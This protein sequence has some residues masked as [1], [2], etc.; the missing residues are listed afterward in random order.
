MEDRLLIKLLQLR[1]RQALVQAVERGLAWGLWG[2]WL[3]LPLLLLFAGLRLEPEEQLRVVWFWPALA[4]IGF[5]HGL[6]TPWSLRRV[7][8]AADQTHDLQER[9]LTCYGHLESKKAHT[10]VSQL[11]LQESLQRLD[12]IDPA[13]TFPARWKRPLLRWVVP[14]LS[15]AAA[16]VLAPIWLPPPAPDPLQQEVL[17]ARQ[18]LDRLSKRLALR[19]KSLRHEQVR[20][21][22]EKLP[23]QVPA[24][25]AR[26]LRQALGELQ[27]QMDKQNQQASQLG[28]MAGATPQQQREQLEKMRRQLDQQPQAKSL[29]EQAQKALQQGQREQAEK[30]MRDAQ[31]E[32]SEGEQMSQD[33]ELSQALED[34]MNQLGGSPQ[35]GKQ[36]DTPSQGATGK[37]TKKGQGKA[38]RGDFGVGSTNQEENSGAAATRK[39]RGERQNKEE[40]SKEGAFKQLYGADRKDLQ[41]RRERIALAGGKGKL[42]RMADGKLGDPR[43]GDPSLRQDSGDFLEAKALAEQSVAEEKVPAEHREAVRRYFDNID[44]RK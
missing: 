4:L 18:R 8:Y 38:G 21:L 43:L 34:E 42:L 17:A 7:A 20:K 2:G 12:Q 5:G 10:V 26:Q 19:P 30:A 23:N 28:Q 33:S 35:A 14:A 39:A 44:P 9:L 31:K 27:R 22:L 29:V 15:L 24:Q 1:R 36:G 13:R 32:L 11:L 37:P 6:L 3:C 41:T 16:L 25:A 40:R